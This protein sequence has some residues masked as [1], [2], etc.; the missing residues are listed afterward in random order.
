MSAKTSYRLS[1]IALLIGAAF[2]IANL[3]IQGWLLSAAELATILSPFDFVSNALGIV[4]GIFVLLGLPGMYAR[5]AER[6]GIIGLLG[7]VCVWYVTLAQN[8]LLTFGN[9]TVMSGMTAGLIPRQ[10]AIIMTP[11]PAWGPIFMLSMV[12]EVLGILLLAIAILRAGV[13]PGWIGWTFV[14]TL[15]LGVVNLSHRPAPV[16][17]GIGGYAHNGASRKAALNKSIQDAGWGHFLS[18]LTFKAACAGKRVEAVNPAYTTQDCSGCG[19][20]V[21]KSLSVRTHVCHTCGL[22]LDRDENAARNILW[23]GQRLRGLAGLPAGMNR[24]PAGL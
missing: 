19:E 16:P 15:V 2:S 24:E 17:D 7:F 12:C 9:L 6:A 1:G 20:R 3:V 22:I 5:Q 18:I 11:P 4:G 14:A 10:P 8:I 23:R 13:F 21:R